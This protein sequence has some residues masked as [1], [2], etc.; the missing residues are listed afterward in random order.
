MD[1]LDRFVVG[2]TV[3]IFLY[4]GFESLFLGGLSPSSIRLGICL[5]LLLY[6][7]AEDGPVTDLRSK[8]VI[9]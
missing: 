4:M 8:F 9:R 6:S 7:P 5:G 2:L 3:A 1:A